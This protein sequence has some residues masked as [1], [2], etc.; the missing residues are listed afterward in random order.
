M[1]YHT[2]HRYTYSGYALQSSPRKVTSRN[3]EKVFQ[4][5]LLN[6]YCFPNDP[7]DTNNPDSY[8][9]VFVD[10]HHTVRLHPAD[11]RYCPDPGWVNSD[12]GKGLAYRVSQ[13]PE[14]HS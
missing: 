11:R 2:V 8:R 13:F 10:I 3:S 1:H 6:T 4:S 14:L 9:E 7:S 12:Q 5:C